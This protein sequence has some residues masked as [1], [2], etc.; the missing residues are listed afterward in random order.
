MS[1]VRLDD[2]FSEHPKILAAGPQA[3]WLWV[4]GLAYCNRQKKKD[5][6][7]PERMIRLLAD[8]RSVAKLAMKLV[9]VGLWEIVQGGFRVHDYHEYQPST[10]RSDAE[11]REVS[12]TRAALGRIGGERSGEARRVA[13]ARRVDEATAK[14]IDANE[15]PFVQGEKHVESAQSVENT[16]FQY[17]QEAVPTKQKRSKTLEAKRSPDPVPDPEKKEPPKAPHGGRG[18]GREPEGL[19][20]DRPSQVRSSSRPP[21]PPSTPRQPGMFGMELGAFRDGVIAGLGRPVAAPAGFSLRDLARGIAAHAPGG[22]SAEQT[23]AWLKADAERWARMHAAPH[24]AKY[25]GG[26]SPSAWVKWRDAGCPDPNAERPRAKSH[27]QPT[28]MDAP[29]MVAVMREYSGEAD[30]ER[31]RLRA[32]ANGEAAGEAKAGGAAW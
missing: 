7:I 25:Q 6:F 8:L 30:A 19:P 12:A 2:G 31:A 20:E 13:M 23:L 22:A 29:W 27:L 10:E 1:W 17:L 4:C 26:F 5:G 14:R 3:G 28:D 9:A 15:M 21:P 16:E 18:D 32:E 24:L 11:R